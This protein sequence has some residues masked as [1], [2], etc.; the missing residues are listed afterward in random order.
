VNVVALRDLVPRRREER[1]LAA[2]REED[3]WLAMHEEMERM[4]EDFF[5]GAEMDIIGDSGFSPRVN[6]AEQEDKVLVSAELPGLEE[7]DIDVSLSRDTLTISGEKKHEREEEGQNFYRRERSYGSFSRSVSIP[8][9]ID[10]DKVEA[11]FK[12]GVLSISLPK[13]HQ[14]KECNKVGIK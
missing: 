6:V 10:R 7:A 12:N 8:C 5:Q 9:P 4:F 3:P 2:R 11:T 14:G 1:G 13:L